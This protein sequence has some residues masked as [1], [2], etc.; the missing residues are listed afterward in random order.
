MIKLFNVSEVASMLKLSKSCLYKM[1]ERGE[2]QAV[3]IG[4]ALRFSEDS[5]RDLLEK[6]KVPQMPQPGIEP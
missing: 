5:L 1:A 3:K 4:T 2:I 6:C